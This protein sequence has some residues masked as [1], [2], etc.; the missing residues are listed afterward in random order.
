MAFSVVNKCGDAQNSSPE[1][2]DKLARGHENGFE[3]QP[4]CTIIRIKKDRS[5]RVQDNTDEGFHG[6]SL[7]FQA[8]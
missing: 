6:E 3:A 1:A 5:R 2:G 4:I 8:L 7:S